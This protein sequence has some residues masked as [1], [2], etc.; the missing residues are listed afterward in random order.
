MP[1]IST[2]DF[3]QTAIR[4]PRH[5][6]VFTLIDETLDDDRFTTTVTHMARELQ[7][8]YYDSPTTYLSLAFTTYLCRVFCLSVCLKSICLSVCLSNLRSV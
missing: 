6:L 7:A 4:V 8:S 3:T 2:N 5:I 1:L